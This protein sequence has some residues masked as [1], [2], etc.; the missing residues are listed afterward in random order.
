[1]QLRDAARRDRSF[2]SVPLAL[3]SGKPADHRV[4]SLFEDSRGDLWIGTI[5][6]LYRRTRDGSISEYRQSAYPFRLDAKIWS[7]EFWRQVLEDRRGRLWAASGTGLW[8]L[9]P[10]GKGDYRLSPA[11]VRRARETLAREVAPIDD[12][13][14]SARYRRLVAQNLLSEFLE[15]LSR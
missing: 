10:D 13:R 15:K 1:M 5:S 2:E 9:E 3:P 4:I 11:L 14:S 6:A 8:Q 7:D 12:M